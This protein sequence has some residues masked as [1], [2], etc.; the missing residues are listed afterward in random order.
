MKF[1]LTK[2]QFLPS[3]IDITAIVDGKANQVIFSHI[4]IDAKENVLLL[5]ANDGDL[6]LSIEIPAKIDE[7]GQI[8]VP[9][10]KLLN[11][12]KNLPREC[13][14]Q[15]EVIEDQFIITSEKETVRLTTLPAR[16]FPMFSLENVENNLLLDADHLQKA[17]NKVEFSIAKDDV[18]FY[19]KGMHLKLVE[20]GTALHA[21]STDGH[22]LSCAKVDVV[23]K[24]ESEIGIIL[25]KKAVRELT[26]L[27]NKHTE[28]NKKSTDNKVN[29]S[30]S[31]KDI[32][33]E[34][35]NY[36]LVSR[37]IDAEYPKYQNIIPEN[38]ESPILVD[39]KELLKS[40]ELAKALLQDRHDGIRLKFKENELSLSGRN[41][42]N[43]TIEDQ[44]SLIN[45]EK[46]DMEISFN[47]N[48][49]LD[50]VKN[51]EAD[52]IQIHVTGPELPCLFTSEMDNT[53]KYVVMPMRL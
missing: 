47:I 25:P 35:Q 40:L 1:S 36:Q 29:L 14:L 11:I 10:N 16:D 18:R 5:K 7:F 49:L 20:E 43:E 53:V 48:Y 28:K 19:L 26:K 50:V 41:I 13:V 6:S 12:V 4:Y 8:T 33:L 15:C 17:M 46:L 2:E 9:A 42:D 45:S 37:L 39:K 44:I 27:L 3:L 23:N 22:R 31:S 38:Q 32:R 30:L 52:K 51:I 21:V 24:I 34:V